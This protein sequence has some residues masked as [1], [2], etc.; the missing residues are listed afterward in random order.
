VFDHGKMEAALFH[1]KRTT[2]TATIKVGDEN[3]PF[4]KEATRWLGAWLDS[5]LTLKEHHAIKLKKFKNAMSRLRR[6][7][8]QISLSLANCRKVMA[9]GPQSVTME[10]GL[11]PAGRPSGKAAIWQNG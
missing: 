5:H 6:L 7:T 8:E 4:N 10:S 9:A 1:E 11:N 2:P 3:V